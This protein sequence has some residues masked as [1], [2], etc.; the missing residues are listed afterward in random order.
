LI[1]G[2][3]LDAFCAVV[4]CTLIFFELPQELTVTKRLKL[5]RYGTSGWRMVLATRA[6]VNLLDDF[7]PS[8]IHI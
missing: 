6:A 7:D 1:I 4:M 3:L 5:H 8:G 2:W